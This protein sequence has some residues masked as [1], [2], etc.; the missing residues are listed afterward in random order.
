MQLHPPANGHLVVAAFKAPE[1]GTYSV[2]HLGVRRVDANGLSSRLIVFNQQG[3]QVASLRATSRAWVLSGATYD[4]GYTTAGQFI[5][6]AVDS[7]GTYDYDATEIAWQVHGT[8]FPQSP[9][10]ACVLTATPGS[11]SQGNGSTLSWSTVNA[12]ALSIDQGIGAVT[13]VASGATSVVPLAT[14]TYRATVS[15]PAGSATCTATVI[16]TPA[17]AQ[18][19]WNSYDAVVQGGSPQ[20]SVTS[21]TGNRIAQLEFYESTDAGGIARNL[22][23]GSFTTGSHAY[24]FNKLEKFWSPG[25]AAS[26]PYAGKSTVDRGSDSG[27]TNIPAPM[28]VRDLQLHPPNNGHLTVAAFKVPDSG[29]YSVTGL[30]VRRVDANGYSAR[31]IVFDPQG[32]QVANL[33]TASQAWTYSAATYSLGTLSAGQYICFAVDAD[34]I[35]DY[36]ATEIAWQVTRTSP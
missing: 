10:P 8:P 18:S 1:S 5:Y 33:Q 34:G 14:T 19:V 23:F 28:G 36:D 12:S 22:L 27:E 24:A 17:S 26:F 3:V 29:S 25:G 13:P 32:V 11:V 16:V 21:V 9:S 2:T 31:L 20:G 30:A 6:F 15:G 35:Y 7:D 4:V